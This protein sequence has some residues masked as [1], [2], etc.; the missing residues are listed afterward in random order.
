MRS[1]V[2]WVGGK[3]RLM[4][5][6]KKVFGEVDCFVEPFVGGA[7]VFMN[8]DYPK[9]IL[10]DSNPDLIR[11]LT[12]AA[13]APDDLVEACEELWAKGC[14]VRNYMEIRDKFNSQT[15]VPIEDMIDR[16]A[17]FIF[18]NRHGYNGL[19][20]YNSKG[21]Y[22]VPFGDHK[23]L[24]ML[25]KAEI[26]AFWRRATE[27]ELHLA[28]CGFE[29]T[30]EKAPKGALIYADPPYVPSSKTASFA[31]YHKATFNQQH[32][33]QLAKLLKEAHHRGCRVVLSNSDTVL[34]R[35]IYY[36]FKWQVVEVG[37][38]LGADPEKRGKVPELIGTLE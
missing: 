11:V 27:C 8:T 31:K 35:D 25:P 32:Q 36:G 22:N 15:V 19:C 38:F 4:D 12:C 2:K 6:L 18:M 34:T 24:P 17:A 5:D 33:R 30:I 26:Q 28:C 23:T 9:Y 21:G 10:T 20:R 16:A 7:S 29:E 1:I 37:R 13:E 14:N 3:Q